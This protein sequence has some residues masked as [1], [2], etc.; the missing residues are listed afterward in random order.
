MRFNYR[1]IIFSIRKR[2]L[3]FTFITYGLIPTSEPTFRD[4]ARM[5]NSSMSF[6]FIVA[7]DAAVTVSILE[8]CE[9][10]VPTSVLY[11][12]IKLQFIHEVDEK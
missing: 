9:E 11:R 3:I 2:Q 8:S 10:A 4:C 6:P 12:R 1:P 5:S 7:P